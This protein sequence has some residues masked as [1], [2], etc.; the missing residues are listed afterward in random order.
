MN[1]FMQVGH[2]FAKRDQAVTIHDGS[3]SGGTDQFD[4]EEEHDLG[5]PE[6]LVGEGKNSTLHGNEI[7]ILFCEQ[8][9]LFEVIEDTK[10][11]IL[12]QET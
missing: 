4:D 10:R 3:V 7:R 1:G 6:T 5:I 2:K 9:V 11:Q 12:V 8:F